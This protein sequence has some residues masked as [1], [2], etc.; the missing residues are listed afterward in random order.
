MPVKVN[1]VVNVQV[2]DGPKLPAADSLDLEAYDFIQIDVEAGAADFE[3][4]VQPGSTTGVALLMIQAATFT[5]EVSYTVNDTEDDGGTRFA[6]DG[7]HLL[8][9]SGAMGFLGAAPETLYF[10]ND[11]AE[12]AQ[13]SILVGRDATP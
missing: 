12:P 3:V 7:L 2:V 9:G 8:V 6:L 11:G 10:Y 5:D 1:W 13:I 4:E